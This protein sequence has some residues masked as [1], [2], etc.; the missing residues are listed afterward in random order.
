MDRHSER[1]AAIKD[2]YL[3]YSKR[4][5]C[6][7]ATHEHNGKI[8]LWGHQSGGFPGSDAALLALHLGYDCHIGKLAHTTIWKDEKVCKYATFNGAWSENSANKKYI[9][10]AKRRGLSCGVKGS[11]SVQVATT[12]NKPVASS[13]TNK[14]KIPPQRLYVGVSD[15][16]VCIDA[17]YKDNY[18][19]RHWIKCL[20]CGHSGAAGVAASALKEARRRGLSCGLNEDVGY[21]LVEKSLIAGSKTSARASKQVDVILQLLMRRDSEACKVVMQHVSVSDEIIW[22]ELKPICSAVMGDVEGAKFAVDILAAA[23][24]GKPGEDRIYFGLMRHLLSGEDFIV[25][26]SFAGLTQERILLYLMLMDGSHLDISKSHLEDLNYQYLEVLMYARYLNQ[27]AREYTTCANYADLTDKNLAYLPKWKRRAE[28]LEKSTKKQRF[29][30]IASLSGHFEIQNELN[31]ENVDLLATLKAETETP[32][33]SSI[34]EAV[35]AIA[36]PNTEMNGSKSDAKELTA[37]KEKTLR[38]E[39]GTSGV[40]SAAKTAAANHN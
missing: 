33:I 34:D 1:L 4:E 9:K 22:H 17:T 35:Q 13:K 38:L 32:L 37:Q 10:E 28:K 23:L 25:P 36:A 7:I 5:L 40:K 19:N 2:K 16:E 15:R 24:S 8:V 39:R 21:S 18:G 3:N 31:F 6:E 20:D 30:C 29:D 14:A 11:G 26:A 27:S 12:M